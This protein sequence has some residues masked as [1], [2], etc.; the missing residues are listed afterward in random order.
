MV[1]EETKSVWN[2]LGI[3]IIVRVA[4]A[5]TDIVGVFHRLD[6]LLRSNIDR[7]PLVTS[8]YVPW[9]LQAPLHRVGISIE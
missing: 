9:T 8:W 1:R 4:L 5:R 2:C 7:T 3:V 6:T